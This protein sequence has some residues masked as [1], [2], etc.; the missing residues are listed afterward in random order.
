MNSET[1]VSVI[2]FGAP[3][4]I[5]NIPDER[6]LVWPLSPK[7]QV[8]VRGPSY[9]VSRVATSNITFDIEL[10]NNVENLYSG[11][12]QKADLDLPPS[13]EVLAI[14]PV[15]FE[16]KFDKKIDK[17]LPVIIPRLGSLP[18]GMRLESMVVRPALIQVSGPESELNG[19]TILETEPIDFRQIRE[20][21]EKKLHVRIP[22]TLTKASVDEVEMRV[23]VSVIETERVFKRRPVEVRTA[24]GVQYTINPKFV[25]VE[26]TGVQNVVSQIKPKQVIPYVKLESGIKKG[27]KV[28]VE[29]DLPKGAEL[30]S[31]DPP[32]ISVSEDTKKG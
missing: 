24:N 5:R 31:L 4:Q 8:T 28:K 23:R 27:S 6:V 25:A 11:Q 13:V 19:V 9:L 29:I 30:I 16:F 21:F 20:S 2:G 26:V 18:E 7:A 32:Q 12:L 1:N 3:I 15:N 14:E 17:E 10:P 22:G